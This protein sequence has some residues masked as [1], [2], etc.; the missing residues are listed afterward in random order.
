MQ[1][2]TPGMFPALERVMFGVKP[3]SRHLAGCTRCHRRME[4][5]TCLKTMVLVVGN[6]LVLLHMA[7]CQVCWVWRELVRPM[8]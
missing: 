2:T 6:L 7:S 5:D 3:A 4:G 8:P 1:Q